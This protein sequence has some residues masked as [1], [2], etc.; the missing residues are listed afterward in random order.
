MRTELMRATQDI[1][2]ALHSDPVFACLMDPQLTA[3]QYARA[4]SVFA[5]FYGAIECAR[6]SQSHFQELS[7]TSECNALSRDVGPRSG[8]ASQFDVRGREELLGALYVA[9]GAAFG[10]NSMR[11]NVASQLPELPHHFLNLPTQSN[12]WR[13]LKEN[14][15]R[16][17][18]DVLTRQRIICGANT[19]FSFI[20]RVSKLKQLDGVSAL[21]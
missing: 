10:R 17:G 11:A 7:L 15:E 12:R 8:Q 20:A 1:H 6:D 14:L 3:H 19:A 5:E 2:Y 9:H 21:S 16:T 18:T 13:S 4:L